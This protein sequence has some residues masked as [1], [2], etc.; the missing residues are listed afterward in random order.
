[1][2]S[3]VS[4]TLRTPVTNGRPLRGSEG[5][6][7][8]PERSSRCT[9]EAGTAAA[10]WVQPYSMD[11]DSSGRTMAVNRTWRNSGCTGGTA[12]QPEGANRELNIIDRA[13]REERE[14]REER[15]ERGERP[16]R[17]EEGEKGGGEPG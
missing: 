17:R 11:D 8:H 3:G 10:P 15:E 4:A 12:L 14:K 6:T 7:P 13:R 1:M 5:G 16:K 9:G 2:L